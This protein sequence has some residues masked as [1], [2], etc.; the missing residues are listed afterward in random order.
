[1]QIVQYIAYLP[2]VAQNERFWH[3]VRMF[4]EYIQET[5]PRDIFHHQ[6][7]AA[8]KLEHFVVVGE[9]WML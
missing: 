9:V 8:L 5:L 6:I 3:G 1:M 2:Y 7:A 4:V